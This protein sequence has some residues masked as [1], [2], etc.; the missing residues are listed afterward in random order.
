MMNPFKA[1][2]DIKNL[3]QKAKQVQEDLAKQIIRVEEGDFVVE[4]D[5]TQKIISFTVQGISSPA[6]VQVLNNAIKK[7]QEIAAKK[8]SELTGGLGGLLGG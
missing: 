6:A 8:V 7:S 5:G 3:Q 1:F 2:G 4:I